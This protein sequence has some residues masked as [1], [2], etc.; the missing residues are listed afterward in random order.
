MVY[1]FLRYSPYVSRDSRE[2][3]DKKI[4]DHV[5]RVIIQVDGYSTHLYYFLYSFSD[6]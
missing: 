1:G 4:D 6:D 3:E 5:I 2:V